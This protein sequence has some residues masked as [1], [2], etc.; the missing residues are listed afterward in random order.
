MTAFITALYDTKGILLKAAP[1]DPIWTNPTAQEVAD[2]IARAANAG[3]VF[4]AGEVHVWTG[5]DVEPAEWIQDNPEPDAVRAFGP[6]YPPV[7]A[8]RWSYGDDWSTT[9]APA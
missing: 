8:Y 5:D 6:G 2:M 7:P 9:L 1:G 3:C 4:D